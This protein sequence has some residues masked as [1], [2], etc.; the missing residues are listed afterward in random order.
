MEDVGREGGSDGGSGE[1]EEERGGRGRRE[2]GLTFVLGQVSE[3]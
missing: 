3:D 1:G 2:R